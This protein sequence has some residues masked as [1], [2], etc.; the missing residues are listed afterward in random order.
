MKNIGGRSDLDDDSDDE[1]FGWAIGK[2]HEGNATAE[3]PIVVDVT[4][5]ATLHR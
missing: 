3:Q 1:E 5:A 4:I 2:F